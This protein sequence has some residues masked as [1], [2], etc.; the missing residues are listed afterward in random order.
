MEMKEK[1]ERKGMKSE[2]GREVKMEKIEREG[3]DKKDRNSERGR[4]R[5]KVKRRREGCERGR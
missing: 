3:G 5:R 4:E 1:G 2:R